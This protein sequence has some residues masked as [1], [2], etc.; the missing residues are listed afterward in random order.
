[1]FDQNLF[2]FLVPFIK[3]RLLWRDTR[4]DIQQT[5]GLR[6]YNFGKKQASFQPQRYERHH[7]KR[8]MREKRAEWVATVISHLDSSAKMTFQQGRQCRTHKKLELWSWGAYE[9][10]S[11]GVKA[12]V[13]NDHLPSF[14]QKAIHATKYLRYGESPA[15]RDT[16]H[17]AESERPALQTDGVIQAVE[18]ELVE[19]K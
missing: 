9:L 5:W 15:R 6:A 19:D 2:S 17:T 3:L 11:I 8:S 12:A 18:T 1:M 16:R 10:D 4:D 14:F 13:L 7:F